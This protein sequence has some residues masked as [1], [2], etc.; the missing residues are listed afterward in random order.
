MDLFSCVPSPALWAGQVSRVPPSGGRL[1]PQI[2]HE[3]T[4]PSDSAE[5]VAGHRAL[6]KRP[7]QPKPLF[8]FME[9]PAFGRGGSLYL[10]FFSAV[11]K[12]VVVHAEKLGGLALIAAGHSE[13][14]FKIISFKGFLEGGQVEAVF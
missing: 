11:P 6:Q 9:A 8:C 3:K 12:S 14:L 1:P 10:V 13:G 2:S 7:H 5:L 4:A